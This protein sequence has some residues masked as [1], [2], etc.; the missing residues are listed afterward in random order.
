M[1]QY[2]PWGLPARTYYSSQETAGVLAGVADCGGSR[3]WGHGGGFRL[4]FKLKA[5]HCEESKAGLGTD[6][7]HD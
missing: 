3:K 7:I 2:T 5:G 1:V 6:T 4:G